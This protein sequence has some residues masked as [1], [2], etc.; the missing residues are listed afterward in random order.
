M[1]VIIYKKTITPLDV[2]N[3]LKDKGV[4]PSDVTVE[5]DGSEIRIKIAKITLTSTDLAKIDSLLKM[6]IRA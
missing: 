5:E 4:N 6:Y 3:L 2:A 1:S